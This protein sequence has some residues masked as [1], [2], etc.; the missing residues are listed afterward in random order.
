MR[1]GQYFSERA[2]LS[3]F[4]QEQ[5]GDENIFVEKIQYGI[6]NSQVEIYFRGNENNPNN[7]LSVNLDITLIPG[8]TYVY[9][10]NVIEAIKR[11]FIS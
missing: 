11:S 6:G 2:R 10:E 5:L 1:N 8:H 7:S 9:S 4:F 3:E